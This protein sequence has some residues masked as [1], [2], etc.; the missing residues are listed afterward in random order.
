MEDTDINIRSLTP[1]EPRKPR[2]R[3][4]QLMPPPTIVLQT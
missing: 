3:L 4:N 1:F 2:L